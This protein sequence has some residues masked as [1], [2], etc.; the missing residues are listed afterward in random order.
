MAKDSNPTYRHRLL[1]RLSLHRLISCPYHRLLLDTL[2]R[3]RRMSCLPHHLGRRPELHTVPQNSPTLSS[4]HRAPLGGLTGVDVGYRS[5]SPLLRR[6]PWH[7]P[8]SHPLLA[9]LRY[10]TTTLHPRLMSRNPEHLVPASEFLLSTC[11]HTLRTM[12]R[13]PWWLTKDRDL[14]PMLH[15]DMAPLTPLPIS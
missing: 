11:L 13:I 1:R 14:H 7:M 6:L 9:R 2:L 3:N 12:H 15:M 4:S 8:I 10:R 5:T